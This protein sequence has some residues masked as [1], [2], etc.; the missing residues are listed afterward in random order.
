MAELKEQDHEDIN[1]KADT[2]ESLMK[3]M[4]GDDWVDQVKQQREEELKGNAKGGAAKNKKKEPPK[5][6]TKKPEEKKPK[7]KDAAGK[8]DASKKDVAAKP[9]QESEDNTSSKMSAIYN[10]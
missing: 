1:G 3:A 5:K 7:G 6:E 4:W 8:G 10:L 2:Y 9:N